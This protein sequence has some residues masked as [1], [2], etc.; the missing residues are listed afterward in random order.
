MWFRPFA[1]SPA[2]IVP[3]AERG[4]PNIAVRYTLDEAAWVWHPDRIPGVPTFVLFRLEFEGDGSP[5]TLQVSADMRFELAL[6]GTLIERGPD[7]G[8]VSHWSFSSIELKPSTGLHTLEALVWWLPASEKLEG[9][10]S[11]RPGFICAAVGRPKEQ[12]HTGFAPWMASEM[13]G[14]KST[15]SLAS[16]YHVIGPGGKIDLS[17]FV[18]GR[19]PWG[20]PETVRRPVDNNPYGLKAP[21]WSLSPSTLP[22]L[23]NDLWREAIIRAVYPEW[24]PD[25]ALFDEDHREHSSRWESLWKGNPLILEP[26]TEHTVLVDFDDYLCGYPLIEL[27]GGEGAEISWLWAEALYENKDG[28]KGN[29]NE[30]SGKYFEGF[31]DRFLPCGRRQF[32]RSHWWRAGRYAL[33]RFRIGDSALTLHSLAVERTGF[34]LEIKARF[35]S[36][37]APL[38]PVLELCQRGLRASMSDVYVDSPYYEQMMYMGDTRLEM[39]MT[40]VASGDERLPRRGIDLIA[41]SRDA[42]GLTA[43]RYPSAERQ[44]SAT[45]TMIWIWML[46]DFAFW[47]DEPTFFASHLG[48]M[49]GILETLAG[50]ENADGL[51]ERPPGWLFMD[52]V[53][54]WHM[55]WPPASQD[56]VSSLVNFQYLLTLQKA[57][58]LEDIAGYSQLADLHRER[59]SRIAKSIERRFWSESLG[60][61]ADDPAHEHWSQHAQIFAVLTKL[62]PP[63]PVA[64]WADPSGS[65]DLAQATIYFQHYLFDVYHLMGR[66]DLI[67]KKLE[68]WKQLV[69]SGLK[70]PVEGPEPSRSD[71]HAWGSHPLFHV[72]ASLAGIRPAAPGFSMV[73]IAPQP[74]PLEWIESDIPHPKG[75]IRLRA[76]FSD[77]SVEAT[78]DL[79]PDTTGVF[80]WNGSEMPL[81]SGSQKVV[82]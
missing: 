69:R 23:R 56:G 33:L 17:E 51:L 58:E 70:A 40:Y 68:F 65:T 78:V 34:P 81:R 22:A 24:L 13:K 30:I 43:E 82:L 72:H 20:T 29:R 75:I 31:G 10:M 2:R 4:A 63:D 50:F 45:F 11:W 73:R 39:L 14:W 35:A 9:R 26:G 74:G 28:A 80:V 52:W 8:D 12:F 5:L 7:S 54:A 62:R 48:T 44:E 53:P 32:I 61:F 36:P 3:F 15:G 79:P 66:G 18:A 60:F 25:G 19:A 41:G 16:S 42:F 1:N 38:E 76:K 64:S 71:C 6:D 21:G 77:K 59:A 49:R 37:D 27:E 47:R 46:H 55:G 67:H 57:A